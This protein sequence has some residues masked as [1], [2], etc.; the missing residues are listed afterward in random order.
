MHFDVRFDP[1]YQTITVPDIVD[2]LSR[3]IDPKTSKYLTNLTIDSRSLEVEE[4][5]K[6]LNA[7]VS[8]QTTVS[9]SPPT[10]TPP[11]PRRCSNLDLSYCKHLPYNVTSYPNI[12]G[13][14][15]L[16]D[17]EEDVIAFRCVCSLS[18]L[19]IFQPPTTLCHEL[20]PTESWST[21]SATG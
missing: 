2:I 4:S 17:V 15:S 1:R 13:H 10:T 20:H 14:R 9:T 12:L 21:R 5:I 3:E 8:S 7:Q 11:P 16:A 18:V 6:A 19:Q